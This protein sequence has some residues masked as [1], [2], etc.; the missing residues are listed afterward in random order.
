MDLQQILERAVRFYPDRL[1]AVCGS[2]RLTYR[3]FAERVR[4]LCSALR[5]PRIPAAAVRDPPSVTR[6]P[7]LHLHRRWACPGGFLQL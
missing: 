5:R 2:T 7:T 3:V 1:A 4:R 6:P